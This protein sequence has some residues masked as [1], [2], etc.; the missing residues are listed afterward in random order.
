MRLYLYFHSYTQLI[1]I[2]LLF[3]S[4][5]KTNSNSDNFSL[6]MESICSKAEGY[7]NSFFNTYIEI[8]EK[9]KKY[10]PN[11]PLK[12]SDEEIIKMLYLNENATNSYII[13]KITF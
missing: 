11:K 13:K 4:I 8:D 2:F 5:N 9:I 3:T 1:F 12:E 6:E 10:S 7:V